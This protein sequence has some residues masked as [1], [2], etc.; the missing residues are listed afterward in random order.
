MRAAFWKIAGVFVVSLICVE[1]FLWNTA[2][3]EDTQ[4]AQRA[5]EPTPSTPRTAA[6]RKP[7]TPQ[8]KTGNPYPIPATPQTPGQRRIEGIKYDTAGKWRWRENRNFLWKA[9]N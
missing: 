9:E 2:A 5:V 4:P 7:A 3:A 1:V 8:E 6:V